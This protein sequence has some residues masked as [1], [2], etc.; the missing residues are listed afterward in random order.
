LTPVVAS[1]KAAGGYRR[2]RRMMDTVFIGV[3]HSDVATFS[4][5]HVAAI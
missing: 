4:T 5:L 2:T 3:V 1:L